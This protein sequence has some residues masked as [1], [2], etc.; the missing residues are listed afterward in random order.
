MG[1]DTWIGSDNDNSGYYWDYENDTDK[2]VIL[3]KTTDTPITFNLQGNGTK[4]NPYV[5]KTWKDW[6]EVSSRLSTSA[7]YILNNDL[8]FTNKQFYMLGSRLNQMTKFNIEGKNKVLSGALVNARIVDYVGISGW[9]NNSTF[10]GLNLEDNNINGNS[11]TGT[12][13]GHDY[14]C[15]V[16]EIQINNGNVYGNEYVGGLIGW[17][18]TQANHHNI[19][20]KDITVV[21][22]GASYVSAIV[23]MEEKQTQ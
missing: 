8:D 3:K 13:I 16:Y 23:Y 9:A 1:M 22:R 21:G 7:Y 11:H 2:N 15:T 6:K 10:Y 18:N 19:L 14:N 17:E 20:V 4:A 12:L 5:I